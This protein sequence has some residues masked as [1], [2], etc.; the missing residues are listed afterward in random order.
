MAGRSTFELDAR[1]YLGVREQLALLSLPPQLR[2]RLLNNVSKRVRT[3]S[4]KRVRDQQN[5]DGSPFEARKGSAK[6]KKKMEAGLAKLMVV[7][8]VSADEAELG[9][10]NALTRWVATQQHHGVSERRTAAQMRRWNKTPPGLAATD[11]QAKRLRRLGF[12]VR[13]A[14]KKTLTRP[15]VAW[16]QEHVNYAK[17][18]L[19][20]RILDDERSESTGAQSWE[21]TL[22]KRQFIGVNTDRDTSLLVNQVLQQILHSSR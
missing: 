14:G 19:L 4:R 6:G 17:A 18:G 12:R 1:G 11:K 15:S 20:I 9:W 2:R 22:P 21:I 3:M 8:R 7:T 5:L 16:I 10:K 13:Q